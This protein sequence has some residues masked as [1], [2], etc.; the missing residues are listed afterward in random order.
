MKAIKF[1]ICILFTI[2]LQSCLDLRN[3]PEN[4]VGKYICNNNQNAENYLLLNEDGTFLHFYKENNKTL[5]DKGTWK[6]SDNG[7]C[8]IEFSNWKNFN[9]A[10]ANFQ[11]FGNGILCING[12]SLDIGPDGESST[13][14]VKNKD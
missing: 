13:S 6:K 4:V 3:C 8:D 2:V 12:N 5:E 14:F 7:Y 9:E 11:E 1:T 10:G